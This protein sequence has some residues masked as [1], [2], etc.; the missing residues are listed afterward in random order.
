M[1]SG[2]VPLIRLAKCLDALHRVSDFLFHLVRAEFVAQVVEARGISMIFWVTATC[3]YPARGIGH[4]QNRPVSMGDAGFIDVATRRIAR[5]IINSKRGQKFFGCLRVRV[6]EKFFKK[7]TGYLVFK[8]S[9][10]PLI[11][12]TI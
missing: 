10:V 4:R 12:Q 8:Y 1:D 3:P 11:K 9:A 6:L 5:M 7:I 2:S